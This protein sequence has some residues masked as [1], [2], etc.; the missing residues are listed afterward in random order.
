MVLA[1]A[2]L[3]AHSI[4]QSPLPV[5]RLTVRAELTRAGE[6]TI[7]QEIVYF[8]P[9]RLSWLIL[10]EADELQVTADG[11]TVGLDSYTTNRR[12]NEI[13]ISSRDQSATTW[14]L[15]YRTR[16][17]LIRSDERDQ[18]YLPILKELGS[19]IGFLRITFTLPGDATG[20]GLIGNL[21]AI[22]GVSNPQTETSG[23]EEVVASA[24]Q[25]GP[26][27]IVTL[28]A[29]WPTTLLRLSPTQELR[30]A[31]ANLELLP[32]IVIGVFLPLLSF[33]I[34][35]RLLV[36]QRHQETVRA[37]L[38][39][40]PPEPLSPLIVGTLVDKKVYPREIVAMLIDLCRR[41]YVVIVK[42]SGQYSLSQRKPLDTNLEPWERDILEALFPIANARV[43]TEQ[44]NQL[45][46][47]SLFNPKIRRAFSAMYDVV[48]SKQ[49]F[50]ENPHQT[51]VRYKL[52]SLSL[53]FTSVV[54]AIWVAVTGATPYLLLP[55]AGT[56]LVCRL[57]MLYTPGLVHYTPRGKAARAAWIAFGQYL[58]MQKPLPLEDARNQAFEKYLGYAVALGQTQGWAKRFDLTNIVIVKPDWFISYEETSTAEFANEIEEF[59]AAIS[60]LLTEM[61]GPIVS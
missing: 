58:S 13:R 41:G 18:V 30:L 20:E 10:S 24:E 5:Q 47:Q 59:S 34:L 40:S 39:P 51:R 15:T 26:K 44:V 6:L 48:T 25:L 35:L 42:K 9:S 32:W 22:G 14:Q 43:T 46:R 53:Y 55:V 17:Q 45:N 61:R 2:M 27:A 4:A 36:R 19:S 57:I 49:F 12:S 56:M 33:L 37:P 29:H 23:T 3:P 16:S 60:K 8:T 54:G 52:F 50:A 21:Y 1:I 28:N 38:Q 31:L 11:K 7:V